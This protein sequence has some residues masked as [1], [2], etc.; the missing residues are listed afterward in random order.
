MNMLAFSRAPL[1]V[2]II[3]DLVCP[4]C[5][6]GT[7]RLVRALRR[8]PE[9]GMNIQWRP[10]LLNPDMPRAGMSRADYVVR[11]FGAEDRARRLFTSITD[12]GRGEGILF[13]FDR[14]RRTPSSVDAHRLVRF[15]AALGRAEV[16]ADALFTAYF[17]DGL[18]IGSL[19]VLVSVGRQCGLEPVAV[20]NHLLTDDAIEQVHG[21]NLRSHRLGINGAPCFIV[22]RRHAIAGAQE[23]E[24]LECLLNVAALDMADG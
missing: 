9:L 1:S 4:W 15:A 24:V 23:P 6:I 3:Y 8:R 22:G 11:K 5:F 14:I 19:D 17:T 16:V 12:I 2:E 10:F 7:R 21:D 13:R 20:R 18:D